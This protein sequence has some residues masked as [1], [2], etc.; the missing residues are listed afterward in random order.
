M[1][2]RHAD[3]IAPPWQLEG[4]GLIALFACS[5]EFG[6]AC[7]EAVPAL[8]G[9]ARGGIGALMLVDYA[10]S[11]VG[12]YRE[13]LIVP[14]RFANEH[15]VPMPA[16]TH[17]WVSTQESV[18]GGRFNWGLPKQRAS[19]RD[20]NQAD[21]HARQVNIHRGG[22]ATIR[23][24]YRAFGPPLPVTT[25]LLRPRWHTL[26]QP[27]GDYRYRTRISAR[28][29]VRAARLTDHAIPS[30]A[31]FADIFSQRHLATL[32]VSRFAMTFPTAE[33]QAMPATTRIAG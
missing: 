17:I 28:G 24:A 9:R 33:I 19:F 20:R 14:G 6:N 29:R 18:D 25:R 30:D 16:V 15:G 13:L 7:A 8:R 11:N 26:D 21:G 3:I 2:D 27:C 1:S 23:L 5:R 10:S 22:S 4:R 32:A 31:G 12:P